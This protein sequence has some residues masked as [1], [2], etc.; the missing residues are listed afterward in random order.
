[1]PK[2]FA[3]LL[4]VTAFVLSAVSQTSNSFDG[5]TWWDHVKVLADDNMEGRDTGSE[6]LGKAE[7]YVVDNSRKTASCPRAKMATIRPS[8][9]YPTR[10]SKKNPAPPSSV[11]AKSSLSPWATM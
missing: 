10:S 4:I 5:H 6:G 11:T 8:S 3:M 1:M 7:G 9:S 2:K